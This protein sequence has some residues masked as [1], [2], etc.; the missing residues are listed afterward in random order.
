MTTR[1]CC[2]LGYGLDDT[3]YSYCGV[4]FVL[5]MPTRKYHLVWVGRYALMCNVA[6]FIQVKCRRGSSALGVPRGGG[7]EGVRYL[8]RL[9]T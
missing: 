4:C 6:S 1:K 2:D 9:K 7:G 8:F 5:K 3:R